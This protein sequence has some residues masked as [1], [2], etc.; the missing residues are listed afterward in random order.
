MGLSIEELRQNYIKT[1]EKDDSYVHRDDLD[2][3]LKVINTLT[4]DNQDLKD[5]VTALEAK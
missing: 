5:R 4:L 2:E 1:F 3:L